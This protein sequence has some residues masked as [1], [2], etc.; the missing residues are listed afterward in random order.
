M[1]QTFVKNLFSVQIVQT[2]QIFVKS[3]VAAH[4]CH[5][6]PLG[7]VKDNVN[8]LYKLTR[9]AKQTFVHQDILF[10]HFA[11]CTVLF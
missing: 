4:L 1:K 7:F 6:Q 8:G 11:N 10:H 9:L 3:V 2:S 5:L